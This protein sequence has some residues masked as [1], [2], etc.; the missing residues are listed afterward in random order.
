M[1]LIAGNLAIVQRLLDGDQIPWVVIGGAAAHLYGDRRPLNDIDILVERHAL[2]RVVH[3]L[4]QSHKAVQS[5]GTR[6]IWRGIKVFADLTVRRS[7]TNH[8]FWLDE[9]MQ[10]RRR[11]MSLLGAQ[12]FLPPPEDIVAHKLLLQR[13]PEQGKHD[14]SDAAGIIR[15]HQLDVDYL[16]MRLQMMNA[17]NIVRPRLSELGVVLPL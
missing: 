7:G 17:L 6:V 16:M 12:V 10:Q 8:P 13:G 3:L 15:R 11:R 1:S 9:P 14:I 2:P 4:Q 5:D